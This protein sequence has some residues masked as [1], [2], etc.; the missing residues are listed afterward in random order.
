MNPHALQSP[1]R[2]PQATHIPDSNRGKPRI[3]PPRHS[4]VLTQSMNLVGQSAK[5]LLRRD[6][7]RA[8]ETRDYRRE[9]LKPCA[10]GSDLARRHTP[11]SLDGRHVGIEAIRQRIRADDLSKVMVLATIGSCVAFIEARKPLVLGVLKS[12]EQ[13]ARDPGMFRENILLHHDRS[14]DRIDACPAEP[15]GFQLLGLLE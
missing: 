8:S 9:F 11:A 3:A 1:R 14:V 6:A 13:R 7:C 4:L 5:V 15:F 12:L 10:S 2:R